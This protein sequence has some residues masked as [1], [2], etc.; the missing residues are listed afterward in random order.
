M[1]APNPAHTG[2]AHWH[3]GMSLAHGLLRHWLRDVTE[4][5]EANVTQI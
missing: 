1:P 3:V 5:P 2:A 4:S